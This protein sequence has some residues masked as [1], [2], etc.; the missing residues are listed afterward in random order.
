M[1]Y[2]PRWRNHRRM[3]HQHFHQGVV[4][5]YR[6]VQLQKSREFL[7]WVLKNPEHT[8]KHVRR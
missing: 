1:P 8:R 2:G 4:D 5:R 3:F 7:L 6:P